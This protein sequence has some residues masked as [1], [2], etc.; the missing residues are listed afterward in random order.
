MKLARWMLHNMLL[1]LMNKLANAP[2]LVFQA[3]STQFSIFWPQQS[4]ALTKHVAMI[5]SLCWLLHCYAICA[6]TGITALHLFNFNATLTRVSK[7]RAARMEVAEPNDDSNHESKVT[8]TQPQTL[9]DMIVFLV[10]GSMCRMCRMLPKLLSFCQKNNQLRW[11]C[12]QKSCLFMVWSVVGSEG[13]SHCFERTHRCS[14]GESAGN[15]VRMLQGERVCRRKTVQVRWL[16]FLWCRLAT[17]WWPVSDVVKSEW[18][19]LLPLTLRA[20]CS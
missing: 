15:E 14:P 12:T 4:L 13:F 11:P 10:L 20:G 19:C 7:L 5:S 1:F 16:L 9:L 17:I 2:Y 3:W 6:G 8:H 18:L